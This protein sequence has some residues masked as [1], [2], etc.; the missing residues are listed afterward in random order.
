MEFLL[1]HKKTY[2]MIAGTIFPAIIAKRIG[3]ALNLNEETQNILFIA[4]LIG[5]GLLTSKMLK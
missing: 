2:L 3:G 1:K 4:G 5:G